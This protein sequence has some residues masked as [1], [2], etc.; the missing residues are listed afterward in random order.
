VV[1]LLVIFR[2]Y[3]NNNN[4]NNSVL[5]PHHKVFKDHPSMGDTLPQ[6]HHRDITKM[7]VMMMTTM[8]TTKVLAIPREVSIPLNQDKAWDNNNAVTNVLLVAV[9]HD[10]IRI[11]GEVEEALVLHH[12]LVVVVVLVAVSVVVVVVVV[13][14]NNVADGVAFSVAIPTAWVWVEVVAR[15]L[16]EVV[17]VDETLEKNRVV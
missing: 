16:D 9:A 4:N 5:H 3:R 12:L 10:R 6:D 1:V 14:V 8:M 7:T 13:V 17:A 11:R 2:L 15:V